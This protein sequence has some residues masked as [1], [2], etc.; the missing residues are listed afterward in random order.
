MAQLAMEK[1]GTLIG[2]DLTQSHMPYQ[3]LFERTFLERVMMI[4]D[5][6]EGEVTIGIRKISLLQ[7]VLAWARRVRGYATLFRAG[8]A[9]RGYI[10]TRVAKQIATDVASLYDGCRGTVGSGCHL[11][12]GATETGAA[13]GSR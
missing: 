6:V 10:K 1:H 11:E 4:W 9:T 7:L 8:R 12:C 2:L 13:L 3:V 5:K